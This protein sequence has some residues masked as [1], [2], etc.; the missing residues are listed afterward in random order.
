MIKPG[1]YRHFKGKL[2]QVSGCCRHSETLEWMVIYQGL[3]NSEDFGDKPVFV[4][5]YDLFIQDIEVEGN[6]V[7]RFSYIGDQPDPDQTKIFDH[8]EIPT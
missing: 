1:L 4:R 6:K 2:Y 5:P 7:P 3:Y 8:V